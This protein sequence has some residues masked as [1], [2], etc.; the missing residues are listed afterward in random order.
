MDAVLAQSHD[1]GYAR[2]AGG[3]PRQ[4]AL[5]ADHR[6]LAVTELVIRQRKPAIGIWPFGHE[7]LGKIELA[8]RRFVVAQAIAR[9]AM[10]QV[11]EGRPL[12]PVRNR[13]VRQGR[14]Q[15]PG[16]Q[17]AHLVRRYSA[18]RVVAIMSG[19]TPT[20][21]DYVL[22][23]LLGRGGMSEVFSAKHPVT[24]HEVAIKVLRAPADDEAAARRF[25]DE[26]ARTRAIEHPNVVRV[27]DFGRDHRGC[28][29]VMERLYGETLA[30]SIGEG[31]D[32]PAVRLLGASIADGMAAAHA[33][34]IVHRDLKPLNIMLVDGGQPKILDFG[35][36]KMFGGGSA[37]ATGPRLG[38]PAYMAPEQLTGSLVAPC[39]D[40]WAFGV[41][42]FEALT[43]RLPFRDF[44]DGRC[45]QLLDAAPRASEL[46]ALSPSLEQLIA[47]CLD[48]EPGKRPATMAEIANRLRQEAPERITQAVAPAL[49]L[50]PRPA[51]PPA[52]TPARGAASLRW[53]M[54]I[55]PLL[56]GV[57]IVT[58]LMWPGAHT[59]RP[60]AG[61]PATVQAK[62]APP[63]EPE[64]A[65]EARPATDPVAPEPAQVAPKVVH[66][67]PSKRQPAPTTHPRKHVVHPA[68][69]TL[70]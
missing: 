19:G 8:K 15:D 51:G 67:A 47:E 18:R 37:V 13:L 48:K 40:I 20:V 27:L 52:S 50:T 10:I 54:L 41:T 53:P 61:S 45:P 46:C 14:I 49:G 1:L 60:A 38:S 2:I 25:F 66:P 65:P 35:I 64:P 62:E 44:H 4:E 33:R 36:A 63:R 24:G 31:L 16:W 29:L 28:Y 26:A 58:Y 69:E 12:D 9:D 56:A 22:G 32:E 59:S 70:D 43:G 57:A 55:P 68:G 3:D 23:P 5:H 7:M 42:L 21:G 17:K 30:A 11:L 39:V 34:G 6:S